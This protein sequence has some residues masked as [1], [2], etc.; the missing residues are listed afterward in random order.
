MILLLV[1]H[2]I[3][4]IHMGLQ[5]YQCT[6]QIGQSRQCAIPDTRAQDLTSHKTG[7]G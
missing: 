3:E 1:Y 7:P 2:S 4:W 5:L 6:M